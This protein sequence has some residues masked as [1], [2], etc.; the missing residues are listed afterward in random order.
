MVIVWKFEENIPNKKEKLYVLDR[1][2]M[3]D[4]SEYNYDG[5]KM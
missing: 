4:R 5:E 2:I 1:E 3:Y